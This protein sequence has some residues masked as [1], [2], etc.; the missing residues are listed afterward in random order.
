V[1]II[2]IRGRAEVL[3]AGEARWRGAHEREQIAPGGRIRTGDGAQVILEISRG[4]VVAIG[5]KTEVGVDASLLRRERD[6]VARRD[7]RTVTL[8]VPTG[9]VTSVL[10]NLDRNSRYN[11]RTPVA[12][13]GVR[14]TV[15][16]VRVREKAAAPAPQ[17][18]RP[19]AAAPAGPVASLL[20]LALVGQAQGG[21]PA[22]GPN[23]E[24]Q[25]QADVIGTGNQGEGVGN[26]GPGNQ[27]QG[28]DWAGNAGGG[29]VQTD[30]IVIEGSV[31]VSAPGVGTVEVEAG[32][33]YS[34]TGDPMADG[35][36]LP[37][38]D[39]GEGGGTEGATTEAEPAF[40][41]EP[42]S[43]ADADAVEE[44]TVT[45]VPVDDATAALLTDLQASG[46]LVEVSFTAPS[47]GGGA[48]KGICN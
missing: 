38:D 46:L 28:P 11:I 2:R 44:P 36:P 45:L 13:A 12:T 31:D 35:A 32:F 24:G 14:G 43:D 17:A 40:E 10:R 5:E 41:P 3:M 7:V 30:V 21:P 6:G 48:T 25:A 18:R 23:P 42:I 19:A 47:I 37:G 29:Q 16:H 15:F 9:D 8:D 33:S 39:A 26:T 1:T 34:V 4:N 22:D 20:A 27:G